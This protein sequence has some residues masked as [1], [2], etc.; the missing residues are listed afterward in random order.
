MALHLQNIDGNG[1]FGNLELNN[2]NAAAAPVSLLAN[3]TINGQLTF[4]Q[5]KLFNINT[6]NLRLNSASSIVNGGTL[7]YI[8]S[9]GNVGDG[10]LTK[11]YSSPAT[12]NFP[13]GVVNYTPGSIGLS[14]APTAYGS[15]TV[16]PVNFEHPNVTTTGRSLTYFW[17][18]KSS[19]FTFRKCNCNS[20][21]YI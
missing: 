5:D 8:K 6:Y 18:V 4:S 15:I 7:R 1:I 9:A 16:I 11:V 3:I 17:R 13:V 21:I 12:F 10:G 19:G 20:W 2:T 14:A